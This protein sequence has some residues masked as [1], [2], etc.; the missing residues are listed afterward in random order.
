MRLRSAHLSAPT[1]GCASTQVY[2]KHSKSAVRVDRLWTLL[3]L[4][5]FSVC[6]V[7]WVKSGFNSDFV[8]KRKEN[9]F[10]N[11]TQNSFLLAAWKSLDPCLPK[12]QYVCLLCHKIHSFIL[13]SSLISQRTAAFVYYITMTWWKFWTIMDKAGLD[14]CEPLDSVY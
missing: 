3:K 14:C 1:S 4:Y 13:Y 8:L 7:F 9:V 11:S 10:A 12:K 5:D 2:T 6:S